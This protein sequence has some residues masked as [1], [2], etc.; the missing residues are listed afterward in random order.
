MMDTDGED[1]DF[2]DGVE[3]VGLA[4]KGSGPPRFS[5]NATRRGK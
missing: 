2:S 4:L 3:T 5:G 1:F